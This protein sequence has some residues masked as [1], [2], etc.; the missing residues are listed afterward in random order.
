MSDLGTL[1]AP[2]SYQSPTW[3]LGWLCGP[4]GQSGD[5]QR[6]GPVSRGQSGEVVHFQRLGPVSRGLAGEVAE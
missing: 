5:F 2:A 3:E 4:V 6:L 1:V